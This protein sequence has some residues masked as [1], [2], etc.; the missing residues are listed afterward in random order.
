MTALAPIVLAILL[1]VLPGWATNAAPSKHRKPKP[2]PKA[3]LIDCTK[4]GPGFVR[5]GADG[6]IKIGGSVD[7]DAG[8][9]GK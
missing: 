6:C 7:V 9:N 2:A 3:E 8:R 5:I 4:Y 1:L